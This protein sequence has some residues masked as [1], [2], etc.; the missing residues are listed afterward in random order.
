DYYVNFEEIGTKHP[1]FRCWHI[2]EDY[3][4]L[5]LYKKGADDMIHGGT[6]ADVSELA[7]FK[8][9]DRTIIPVTGLPAEGKFGGE[10]YGENGYAYMAVT[11]TTGEHPAF[12]KIDTKTGKAVKGLT[13]EADAITTVGKMK[14]PS[15]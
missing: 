12:Y 1:I 5:Q 11:V 4:L 13:V 10:P 7:I 8:A 3:F 6:S 14:Y 2:S 15:K 9:E